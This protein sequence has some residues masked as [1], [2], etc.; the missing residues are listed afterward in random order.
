MVVRLSALRTGR[1]YPQEITKNFCAQD[2]QTRAQTWKIMNCW[3]RSESYT[4]ISEKRCDRR[5]EFCYFHCNLQTEKSLGLDIEMWV[6]Q[7]G[8]NM[9]KHQYSATHTQISWNSSN[10]NSLLYIISIYHQSKCTVINY[11]RQTVTLYRYFTLSTLNTLQIR[12]SL[13]RSQMVSWKFSLT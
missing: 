10:R 6:R 13:V 3:R 8:S 12:R 1:I 11:G 9:V 2:S 4:L 5:C 7:P